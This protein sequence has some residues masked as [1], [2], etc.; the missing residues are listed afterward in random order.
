MRILFF[1]QFHKKYIFVKV[2][3]KSLAS[4]LIITK[5][6]HKKYFLYSLTHLPS[7]LLAFPPACLPACLPA[8]LAPCSIFAYLSSCY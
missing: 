2:G 4:F 3:V 5:E 8:Y 7:R 1:Q 6:I